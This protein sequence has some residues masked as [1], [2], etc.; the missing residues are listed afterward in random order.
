MKVIL[1]MGLLAIVVMLLVTVGVIVAQ[2]LQ[3]A[4]EDSHAETTAKRFCDE[5][6]VGTDVAH[7]KERAAALNVTF[8]SPQDSKNQLEVFFPASGFSGYICAMKLDDNRITAA[9]LTYIPD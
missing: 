1:R 9:R 4:K 6:R 3:F 5:M 8:H 7:A 2:L